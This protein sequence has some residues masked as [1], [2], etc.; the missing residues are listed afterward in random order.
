VIMVS[1]YTMIRIMTGHFPARE[2]L[3]G[4]E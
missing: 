4:E 1:S 2:L 3:N